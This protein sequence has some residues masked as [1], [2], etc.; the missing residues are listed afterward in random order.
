MLLD[1]NLVGAG[2]DE[3]LVVG[4]RFDG[5]LDVSLA[6][7]W[8]DGPRGCFAD[9]KVLQGYSA[10]VDTSPRGHLEGLAVDTSLDRLAY[11]VVAAVDC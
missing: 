1:G 5:P 6:G 2:F 7:K 10:D 3:T 11:F 9:D 8:F 4:I